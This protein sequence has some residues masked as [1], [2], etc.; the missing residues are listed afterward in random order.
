MDGAARARRGRLVQPRRPRPGALPRAGAAARR[1]RA[2]HRAP[3]TLRRALGVPAR[4]A[5]DERRPGAH[6]RRPAARW[7]AVPGLHDPRRAPPGPIE[8]VEFAARRP[9]RR[10]R[11]RSRRSP[12]ARGVIVG[13]SNPVIS[14]G[15]I[16]AVPGM[17]EALRDCPGA[18]R[19]GLP[20]RRRRGAQGPDRGV[21]G[22][23]GPAARPAT[24][25]RPLRRAARRPRG[26]RARPTTCPRWRPTWRCP[27]P[28]AARARRARDA[29]CSR[30]RSR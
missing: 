20:A 1:R 8:D 18:G 5:A 11:R 7:T 21:P 3:T 14:I 30:S 29:A 13:P 26:R 9:P 24:G 4:G 19:R 17:R 2:A 28:P 12:R 10:R 22:L 27:T 15:P 16:L 25:S 6:A 23:G